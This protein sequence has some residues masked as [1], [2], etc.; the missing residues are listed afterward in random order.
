MNKLIGTK[1][2]YKSVLAVAVPILIQNG[3]TTFVSLLDNIMIGQV[4]TE[5]MSGVAIVNQILFV[6]NLALFGILSGASIFGAQFYGKGDWDGLRSAF[7]F[8]CSAGLVVFLLGVAV[9]LSSGDGLISLF[10][11]E[12]EAGADLATA[13][14]AGSDYLRIMLIGLLPYAVSQ[15]YASTL[16]ET[17]QTLVPMYGGMAAVLV[18][19]TFNYILIFGKLGAPALGVAGAAIATVLARFVECAVVL[20]WTHRNWAKNPFIVGAFETLKVPRALVGQII[21]KGSPLAANEVLWSLGMTVLVQCYSLRGLDVVA[22]V[23]ITNTIN[24][25]FITVFVAIGSAISILVGQ[26]LGANRLEEARDTAYKSIFFSVLCCV[27]TGLVMACLSPLFPQIYNTTPEVRTLAAQLTLVLAICMPHNAFLHATYF[28]L[29]SGGKTIITFFFDSVFTWAVSIPIAF[30]L[31]RL[32]DWPILGIY[33]AVNAADL[34]KCVVG[35]LLI[36]SGIWLN[37]MA[38]NPGLSKS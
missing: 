21:R 18:N 25:V 36:R 30:L 16:R 7:R 3:I 38:D 1:A 28:T 4:G 14:S 2:F 6:Y 24:N 35:F 29:R 5:Q 11:H 12:S 13:L 22:A 20:I 31:T 26:L 33:I 15:I 19:L 23:N 34:F 17:G 27:G 8:K 37:N 32:T 9:F 10:L